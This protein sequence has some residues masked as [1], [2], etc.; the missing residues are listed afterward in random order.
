MT[1][2]EVI[3]KLSMECAL[4]LGELDHLQTIRTYIQMALS[5]GIDHFRKEMEE[6]VV[7][8]MY[9]VECG[10]YKSTIETSQKL[11]ICRQD[12]TKV[13]N[14]RGHTAGGFRFM[15]SRDYE[16]VPRKQSTSSLPIVPLS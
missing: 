15:Y 7:V 16:L 14:G 9:G 12:I 11:G 10:R 1:Q 8:D 5:I 6:I 4:A 13:L 2:G 3:N